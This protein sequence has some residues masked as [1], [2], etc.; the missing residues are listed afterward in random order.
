MTNHP[1]SAQHFAGNGLLHVDGE[2]GRMYPNDNIPQ[3][4]SINHFDEL[5]WSM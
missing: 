1:I 4:G 2:A 3:F 5:Y